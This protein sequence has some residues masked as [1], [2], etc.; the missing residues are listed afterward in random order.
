MSTMDWLQLHPVGGRPPLLSPFLISSFI[1]RKLEH[2]VRA[3]RDPNLIE[4]L[5]I[6]R[7]L[8]SELDSGTITKFRHLVSTCCT[9]VADWDDASLTPEKLRL[10]GKKVATRNAEKLLLKGMKKFYGN[11]L[12]SRLSVDSKSTLEGNW[13]EAL[14]VTTRELSGKT[15]EP[16]LLCF[17]PRAHYEITFAKDGKFSQGQLAVLK[18]MP[19]KEQI[20]S[21]D[22]IDIFVAP[23]G[24][25]TV[26]TSLVT[27]ENFED[28]G[29]TSQRIGTSPDRPCLL[30]YGLAAKRKQYGLRH[31]IAS[32]IHS[33]M[34][35]DLEYVITKVS[36]QRITPDY[37][38]WE[39]EQVV[40]LMSRTHFAKNIIFVGPQNETINALV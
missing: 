40:V 23:E 3:S 16:R 28:A 39:R 29:W 4:I 12:K 24:C 2:S 19:S 9:F 22:K 30:K 31:R 37:I 35:Q 13:Q 1:Y 11:I 18:K 34:G 26:P 15:K 10:F 36:S 8:P 27:D 20:D 25:K 17:Y 33:G 38:L 14:P 21:W 7:M 6:A 32:T 5:R